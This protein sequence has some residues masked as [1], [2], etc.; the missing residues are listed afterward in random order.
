[1]KTLYLILFNATMLCM[2]FLGLFMGIEGP[3]NIG[4]FMVWLVFMQSV[5][6]TCHVRSMCIKGTLDPAWPYVPRW[7]RAM[8]DIC[9][10]CFLVWHGRWVSGA[11]YVAHVVMHVAIVEQVARIRREASS[12]FKARDH[13]NEDK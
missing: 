9:V 11:A 6:V 13:Y 4:L 10:I 1:M 12:K 2:L 8:L 7:S 3:R 5:L